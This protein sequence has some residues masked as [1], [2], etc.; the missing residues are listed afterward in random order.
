VPSTLRTSEAPRL[1]AAGLIDEVQVARSRWASPGRLRRLLGV[2]WLVDGC[3]QLQPFMFTTGLAQDVIAPSADGQPHWVAASVEAFATLV[4]THP[5][6]FNGCF[7]L[8]EVA[9]GL[10]LL[11]LRKTSQSRIACAAAVALAVG[12]WWFGE[13]AGGIFGGHAVATTG[14]PGAALLYAVVVAAAWPRAQETS[15]DA[16]EP[17][18][19]LPGVWCVLWCLTAMLS[20]LPAERSAAGLA[21][22]I[23]MGAMM[24]PKLLAGPEYTLAGWTARLSAGAV[25]VVTVTLVAAQV[26]IGLQGLMR[27]HRRGALVASVLF[28]VGCWVVGQGFGGVSTGRA[29]DVGTGPVLVL[30]ACALWRG[31]DAPVS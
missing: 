15:P 31:A 10:G 6:V 27:R 16:Q 7:A 17:A 1:Q 14:A 28:T 23:G 26:V 20:A 2:L 3:L 18:G 8:A 22:Q 11:F 29:T 5:A 24:S 9:V 30:L 19:W 13:G 12:I 21:D 25:I 4:A